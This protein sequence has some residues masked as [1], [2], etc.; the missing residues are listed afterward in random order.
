VGHAIESTGAAVIDALREAV[1]Q[2][3][4]TQVPSI[5]M[6]TIVIERDRVLDVFGALRDA[7][8]LQFALLVELTAA[9]YHPADPRFEIVYHLACI[10]DAYARGGQ[11]APPRRLR[12][13]V[14]LSGEDVHIASLTGL[15]P[16]A[17]WPEREVYDLF[18]IAFDGH[19]D[20]RRILMPDEW[21][22]HP[23][24]KDYPVQ[25]RRETSGW[26]A[27]QMT[28]DEFAANVQ[29]ARDRAKA[30]TDKI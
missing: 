10:G 13:K 3:V 2:A 24:R 6:A 23:L 15:Y 26:S 21:E 29:A 25:I 16:S 19:R 12:V 14:R 30:E 20:M 17:G 27:L 1:P 11:A 8:A 22:G 7:P 18:G 4:V 9:D 5:D 28:A